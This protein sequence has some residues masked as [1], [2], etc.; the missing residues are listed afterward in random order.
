MAFSYPAIDAAAAQ[1]H[2]L[3]AYVTDHVG[4][5][6]AII[7][8]L[9]GMQ[10]NWKSQNKTSQCL[11]EHTAGERWLG[12]GAG[13][14]P[15]FIACPEGKPG[16]C[17]AALSALS[18]TSLGW[19]RAGVHRDEGLMGCSTPLDPVPCPNGMEHSHGAGS[20][21]S[22]PRHSPWGIRGVQLST[23]PTPLPQ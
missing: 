10:Q 18:C 4:G 20:L 7:V 19:L 11:R 13:K 14:C 1:T 3:P 12:I 22:H 23:G 2:G 6:A 5:S 21:R 15:D 16:L 9:V 17:A 8:L